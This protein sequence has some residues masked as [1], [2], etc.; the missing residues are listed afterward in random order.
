MSSTDPTNQQAAPTISDLI[1]DYGHACRTGRTTYAATARDVIEH[2]LAQL[3]AELDTANHVAGRNRDHAHDYARTLDAIAELHADAHG[4]CAA[5]GCANRYPCPT[6]NET[7]KPHRAPVIDANT[8]AAQLDEALTLLRQLAAPADGYGISGK[9]AFRACGAGDGLVERGDAQVWDGR[10]FWHLDCRP[11]VRV[12]HAYVATNPHA[13]ELARAWPGVIETM[14]ATQGVPVPQPTTQ[15]AEAG[16]GELRAESEATEGEGRTCRCCEG[17]DKPIGDTERQFIHGD[18]RWHHHCRPLLCQDA[19]GP[20]G[21]YCG[22]PV[23]GR[24]QWMRR[25]DKHAESSGEA[26]A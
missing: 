19:S 8:V 2:E 12:H 4:S 10:Q 21:R 14:R 22:E 6:L 9:P 24:G 26:T 13:E 25:C 11:E 1:T 18:R 15:D 20:V 17:C 3:R 16:S 23:G 7:R 5:P